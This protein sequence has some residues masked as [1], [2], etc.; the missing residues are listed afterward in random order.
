MVNK[1]G[2][3]Y[4]RLLFVE[5]LQFQYSTSIRT[6]NNDALEESFLLFLW[7]IRA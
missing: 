2:T 5:L 7:T 6:I 4:G 1:V 3:R